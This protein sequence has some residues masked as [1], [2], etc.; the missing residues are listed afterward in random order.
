[1]EKNNIKFYGK[2]AVFWTDGR[3]P[4]DT[5]SFVSSESFEVVF[6]KFMEYLRHHN[7][8]VL[9]IF[10]AGKNQNE[11]IL[12][13]LKMLSQMPLQQVITRLPELSS[14][15][16]N[17]YYLSQ[18]V[19]EFY[20]F[21]R[22]YERFLVCY[23]DDSVNFDKKPYTTFNYTV[24]HIN[25]II[26]KTYRETCE[27]ITGDHPRIYRQVASGFQ[28]GMIVSKKNWPCP[29][30]YENVK[31]IP[32]IRQVLL[33]PPMIIDPLMNKRTGQFEKV[34]SNPLDSVL[35]KSGEWQCYPAK[36]GDLLIHVYFYDK[37]IGL[38]CALS[39]LFELADDDDITKKPDAI[40]A[41]GVSE[42]S[43][44]KFKNKK[45]VF[46]ED[47]KNNI[48]VAAVPSNDEFGY[49]GYLK[50]M[51]LT[52][53]N[54]VMMKRKR[55]PIHGA[56][57]N[58]IL[59][60]GKSANVVIL[61]DTGAGKSESLEAFRVLSEEHIKHMTIVF[62]DMGSFEIK[63]NKLIAYGTE[64]GAFVR[65]DD[66]QPGF[67]FGNLD[68]SIIMSP[69]KINARAVI[70]VTTIHDVLFGFP[71]DYLL[72]ANNYE[73]IDDAHPI[74]E[75]F[76]NKDDALMVFREGAVMS[77]GTTT[78]TGLVH[79]YFANIFGP[80][81]YKE[82]HEEIA[83]EFFSFM[84]DKNIFVGQIRTRLGIPGFEMNGPKEAAKALFD[85]I[86]SR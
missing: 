11:I 47:K 48:L 6:E 33:Y 69:Q 52:L 50:K 5:L 25:D 77:K 79:T 59:K 24:S 38:G 83:K 53:H 45:T 28:V 58:I 76:A 35:F 3:L 54:I 57:V 41:F 63:N 62:D 36:V 23:S 43:L 75:K 10:P 7:H 42:E 74:L 73:Q 30:E 14:L 9:D 85:S 37:F 56:M 70:P 80:A 65:L 1:M 51:I 72:Y 20:N 27:N 2:T 4:H 66:L 29:N 68:R 18:F 39:N 61:G 44:V 21:W 78:T 34:D 71:V 19:E 64:T 12:N 13:L 46:Y 82:T 81:Q 55:M 84:F 8:P 49:F 22:S 17:V 60:N 31:N 86:K 16:K 26:R 32:I 15:S 67:A 40:Y